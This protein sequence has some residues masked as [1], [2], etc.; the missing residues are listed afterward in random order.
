MSESKVCVEDLVSWIQTLAPIELAEG[1]DNVGLLLGDP[2]APIQRVMTCL[3]PTPESVAEAI[4]HK[5]Q[6]IVAHHPMPFQPLKKITTETRTGRMMHDLIRAGI[7]LHSPHTGFDSAARGINQRIAEGLGLTSIRALRPIA[8]AV[9]PAIGTGRIGD[10]A[11]PLSVKDFLRR[12]ATFFQVDGLHGIDGGT[13]HISRVAIGCGAAGD[14][15]ADAAAAG[16]DG[17]VTGE[18]RFHTALEA[19]SLGVTVAVPG[20]HATERFAVEQLATE[21][22]QA[23][24]SLIVWPS[25]KETDP[26]QWYSTGPVLT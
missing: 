8:A 11:T 1:W 13:G 6:M 19:R 21:L 23:F 20:H 5:A 26:L 25:R 2:A 9:N 18:I 7:A 14:F 3:T 16:C 10:L 15:L 4:E 24:P 17:F 12:A 22:Q